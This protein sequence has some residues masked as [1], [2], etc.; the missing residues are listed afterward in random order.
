[1]AIVVSRTQ[2]FWPARDDFKAD[3]LA[4]ERQQKT[5][6]KEKFTKTQKAR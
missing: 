4:D 2:G 1:M 5:E 6:G 3:R